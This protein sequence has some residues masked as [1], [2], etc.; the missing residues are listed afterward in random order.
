M[1]DDSMGFV[2]IDDEPIGEPVGDLPDDPKPSDKAPRKIRETREKKKTPLPPW[3]A[4]QISKFVAGLYTTGG[5]LFIARGQEDYGQSIIDI[6]EPAGVVWEK[7]AKRHEW[8]RR[9]FD[10]IM[11]TGELSELFMIH[12]PLFMLALR[13]LGL[14]RPMNMQ[15][16]E[17]FAEEMAKEARSN[18][19]A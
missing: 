15:I 11:T 2:E 7:L 14:L 17:E 16:T 1:S 8:L 12:F 9:F 5:N 19:A 4:G 13:D 18:H 6:A 10:R 3:R